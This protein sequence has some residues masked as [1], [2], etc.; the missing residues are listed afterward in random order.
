MTSDRGWRPGQLPPQLQVWWWG[1]QLERPAPDETRDAAREV[2][3]TTPVRIGDA[4]RDR[5][6]AELGDHF[7]AGRLNREEFD[8]RADQAMQARFSSDL[9]PLFADLPQAPTAPPPGRPTPPAP[10][11][12]G[13][14]QLLWL[15]PIMMVGAIAG[16]VLLHAPFLIW[17][18]LWMVIIGRLS[19]QRRWHRRQQMQRHDWPPHRPDR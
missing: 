7:A 17:L 16:A 10:A 18:V 1:P 13:P 6:L 14:P 4:E 15:L 5:A 19:G 8:Q 11:G 12:F 2:A 9:A 3:P